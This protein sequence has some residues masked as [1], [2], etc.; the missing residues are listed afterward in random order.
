MWNRSL[1][2]LNTDAETAGAGT[3]RGRDLTLDLLKGIAMI[4]VIMVHNAAHTKS[5]SLLDMVVMTFSQLAIPCFFMAAGAVYLNR[6]ENPAGA[7]GFGKKAALKHLRRILRVYLE[8]AFWKAVY[9]FVYHSFGAPVPGMRDILTYLFF[10]GSIPGVNTAHFWFMEAYITILFIAPVL[11]ELYFKN[12]GLFL[13]LAGVLFMFENGLFGAGLLVRLFCQFVLHKEPFLLGGLGAVNPLHFQ[14]SF[15][16]LYYMAGALLYEK[17]KEIPAGK[18]AAAFAAGL[19]GLILIRYSQYE[20]FLWKGSM[21]VSG[22]FWISTLFMASGF[23]VLVTG[24]PGMFSGHPFAAALRV[25]AETIGQSTE[26]IFYL[27]M[28]MLVLLDRA[29]YPALLPY[30]GALLCAAES[31]CIAAAAAAV[32]GAVSAVKAAAGKQ[33]G[34]QH[35]EQRGEQQGKTSEN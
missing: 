4:L 16:I 34:E 1:K 10:F 6:P 35:G 20:T 17:R 22:H 18:A 27:H 12:R 2:K 31:L 14:Y 23:F 24:K 29:M 5:E 19:L 11:K 25:F 15:C 28:P 32:S 33:K 9:L 13:Y 30:D 26:L 3:A 21:V 8:L 7:A